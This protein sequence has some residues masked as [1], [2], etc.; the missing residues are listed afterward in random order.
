MRNGA[1]RRGGSQVL[2]RCHQSKAKYSPW[3][4]LTPNSSKLAPTAGTTPLVWIQ[5][6]RFGHYTKWTAAQQ[7]SFGSHAPAHGPCPFWFI[8][9]H[10]HA[11]KL[12]VQMSLS[13]F[14]LLSLLPV[15][16]LYKYSKKWGAK[17]ENNY[18]KSLSQALLYI[19][20]MASDSSEK[21]TKAA[22]RVQCQVCTT[23]PHTF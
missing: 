16:C 1:G 13:S 7:T 14:F 9:L 2:R 6:I 18:S 10:L 12:I 19:T 4:N 8:T 3:K 23:L 17:R 20:H 5:G 11:C 21:K 22:L 15:E